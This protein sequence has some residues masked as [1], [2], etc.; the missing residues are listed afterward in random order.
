MNLRKLRENLS[1]AI[2]AQLVVLISHG[3]GSLLLAR[4]LG[5]ESFGYWQ[6]FMLY[7]G[8][9]ALTTLGLNDGVYLHNN[10]K[11][12]ADMDGS[13]V[14]SQLWL[15]VAYQSAFAVVLV[16]VVQVLGV[17][18]DRSFVVFLTAAFMLIVNTTTYLGY[19]LQA[20]N[21]TAQYS[22]GVILF[23]C[24]YMSLALVLLGLGVASFQPYV[25]A[26]IVGSVVA[27]LYVS[28]RVRRVLRGRLSLG[29]AVGTLREVLSAGSKLMFAYFTAGLTIGAVR[30]IIDAKWDIVVFGKVSLALSLA[31]LLVSFVNPIS[32]VLSPALM[33][34]GDEYIRHFYVRARSLLDVLLPIV[35]LA[36]FPLKLVVSLWLPTYSESLV[37]FA[38]FLPMTV[39][40]ARTAII[41]STYFRVLRMEGQMLAI[42]LTVVILSV[43]SALIA[44]YL[45]DSLGA[46]IGVAVIAGVIRSLISESVLAR[47][48]QAGLSPM[49][50]GQTLVACVFILSVSIM[51]S[52]D[53]I[54][55]MMLVYGGY[56]YVHRSWTAELADR[57]LRSPAQSVDK[58]VT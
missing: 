1:A 52:I 3:L 57:L 8:Y 55:V 50:V 56:L 18:P 38:A 16:V 47:R 54:A 36:Y 9:V 49:L 27:L 39:F 6:L 22:R 34:S 26:Y 5:P 46:V 40:N 19:I 24:S 28:R 25:L 51:S 35:Y 23:H 20:A 7:T 12:F 13:A 41:S 10:G 15:G 58:S 11:S 17:G 30:F 32:M 2:V 42:N 31:T 4:A 37:W 14:F 21:E 45:F 43:A 53:A 44:G 33:H 29:A 48:M